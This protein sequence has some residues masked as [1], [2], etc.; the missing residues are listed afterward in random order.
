MADK[1]ETVIYKNHPIPM[2]GRVW[3]F[4][5]VT[6]TKDAEGDLGISLQELEKLQLAVANAICGEDQPLKSEE[7]DF[8]MSITKSTATDVAK[9]L[10]CHVSSVGKWRNKDSV[11]YLE[12]IALKEIFWMKLFGEKIPCPSALFG[13]ERLAAMEK[14]AIEKNIVEHVSK[15]VA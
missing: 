9:W 3:V 13:K 10:G 11:P 5:S 12:S 14:I 7:F 15:K 8:L 1:V 6:Y 2:V 4:P